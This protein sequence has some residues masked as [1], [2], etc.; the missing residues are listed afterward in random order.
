MAFPE[1]DHLGFSA[2]VAVFAIGSI[3]MAAPLPG[4]TGSY[5]VLVPLGLTTLYSIPQSDAV[6]F[7]FVFHAWQTLLMIVLGV[8]GFVVSNAII[9]RKKV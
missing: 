3:A 1:T 5:H 4:G 8:I 7:V 9:S 2:V 6:A